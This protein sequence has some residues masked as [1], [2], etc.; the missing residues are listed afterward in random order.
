V[1]R[2]ERALAGVLGFDVSLVIDATYTHDR[3][4]RD[5]ELI[6]ADTLAQV[7]A[8]NFEPEFGRVVS[9][10][11]AIEKLELRRVA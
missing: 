3:I 8:V 5:G 2:D 9:T 4:T 7:T 6:T 1:L 11:E 10:H